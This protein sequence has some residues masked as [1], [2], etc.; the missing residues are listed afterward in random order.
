MSQHT[1]TP[2][3]KK[4]PLQTEYPPGQYQQTV[5]YSHPL[6]TLLWPVISQHIQ[7]PQKLAIGNIINTAPDSDQTKQNNNDSSKSSKEFED[8]NYKSTPNMKQGKL[9]HTTKSSVIPTTKFINEKLDFNRKKRARSK[10]SSIFTY[11]ILS[12]KGKTKA[13]KV[14]DP[15]KVYM[16]WC[17][18]TL[19]S[20][21]R[22]A[23]DG[24]GRIK[25]IRS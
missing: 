10:S 7:N 11:L 12:Y 13:E 21:I 19:T 9:E 1:P 5:P 18:L 25:A 8:E 22:I 15:R 16:S 23:G 4:Y 17:Y 20:V 6:N 3:E 24:Q 14:P 2:P